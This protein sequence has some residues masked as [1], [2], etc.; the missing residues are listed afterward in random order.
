MPKIKVGFYM[1]GNNVEL[2]AITEE[3]NLQPTKTRKKK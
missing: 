3:L 1:A 2:N